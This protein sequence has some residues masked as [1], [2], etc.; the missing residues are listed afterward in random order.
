LQI[1]KKEPDCATVFFFITFAKFIYKDYQ[2]Q[3]IT[4]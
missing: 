2:H 3:I 1:N 4:L